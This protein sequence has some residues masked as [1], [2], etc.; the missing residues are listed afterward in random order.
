[1]TQEGLERLDAWRRAREF[2]LEIY[3]VVIPIMPAEEK[4]NLTDQIRRAAISIPANIAE[5]Y[6]RYYYKSN[7]QF[8]YNARGS[9]EELISHL[10]MAH[11]LGY[12]ND[13]NF[14]D[15][16]GKANNLAKLINGYIAFLKREKAG[17]KE[18]VLA[19]ENRSIYEIVDLDSEES[20][21]EDSRL[22]TLDSRK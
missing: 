21:A 22:S 7:V 12:V 14:V 9:L 15:I 17:E 10:V 20:D 19:K 13:D 2:A 18:T 3:R 4:Y 6:G 11:D 1:M 8:C 5:G 16:M